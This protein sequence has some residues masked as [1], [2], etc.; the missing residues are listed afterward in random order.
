MDELS[1]NPD[2]GV[3]LMKKKPTVAEELQWFSNF[4]KNFEEGNAVATVAEN[5]NSRIV[6][7]CEVERL[8][9]GTY[10]SHRGEL[11]L[12]V[13]KEFRGKGIGTELMQRTLE[14]CKGKFDVVQ[15]GVFRINPAKRLYERLGFQSYG[16]DSFGVKRDNRFFEIELMFLKF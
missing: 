11:G 9:P 12:V 1:D 2:L 16:R 3:V 8:H 10:I 5:D 7:M 15:L 13:V 14:K 6:G 4:Y